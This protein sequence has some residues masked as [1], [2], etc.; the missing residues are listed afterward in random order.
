MGPFECPALFC[1]LPESPAWKVCTEAHSSARSSPAISRQEASV[2]LPSIGPEPW[3]FEGLQ[4]SSPKIPCSLGNQAPPQPEPV[5]PSLASSS[6]RLSSG[7]HPPPPCRQT[8]VS[9]CDGAPCL[10]KGGPPSLAVSVCSRRRTQTHT[11][12]LTPTGNKEI[13]Q[14]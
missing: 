10:L 2:G 5:L 9:P 7:G 8:Q 6:Q 11:L 12:T 4:E 14:D 3:F 13:P 1:V